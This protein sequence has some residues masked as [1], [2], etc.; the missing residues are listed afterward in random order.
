MPFALRQFDLS[1]D[2]EHQPHV[3]TNGQN[4]TAVHHRFVVALRHSI[5]FGIRQMRLYSSCLILFLSSVSR[6]TECDC[7]LRLQQ[8]GL[9]YFHIAVTCYQ[10]HCISYSG[11]KKDQI[12]RAYSPFSEITLQI[13]EDQPWARVEGAY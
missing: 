12:V 8:K 9:S 4:A 5:Y 11:N 7:L 13:C 6:A 1:C 3:F 2:D 10:P